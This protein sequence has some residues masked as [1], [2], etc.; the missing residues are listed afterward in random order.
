[1]I[2]SFLAIDLPK[3]VL[4]RI[5][6]VQEDLKSSQA[7]VRWVNPEKIHLTLKFF[8][9]IEEVRIEAIVKAIEGSVH[10]TQAFSIGVKGMGAFP[11]W[12]SPR[13]IW[14]GLVD[15]KGEKEEKGIL[16]P[17][18]KQLESD[19]ETIGF[20]P[21]ARACQPHLTLGRVNSSRGR[22]GLIK[23]MEKYREEEFGEVE[24]ERVIV[25]KSDL[26]PTGPIYTPLRDVKL[27]TER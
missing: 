24:V 27:G 1:M 20:E 19:L 26:R 10:H 17:F 7:D 3:A 5:E 2:R 22:E 4:K 23:R 14:M 11:N 13:V 15:E 9:Y 6:D 16:I 25:F 18:Q 12:R 8:G 21:E